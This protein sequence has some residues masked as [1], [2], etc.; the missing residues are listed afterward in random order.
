[1]KTYHITP[2]LQKSKKTRHFHVLVTILFLFMLF[3]LS[4]C[5]ST[6][7]A[8]QALFVCGRNETDQQTGIYAV[9]FS[10]DEAE[11]I[12]IT[13][14]EFVSIR[15]S[16]APDGENLAYTSVRKDMTGDGI[17][18]PVEDIGE[19]LYTSDLQGEN[20]I[21]VVYLPGDSFELFNW[22]RD[23]EQIAYLTNNDQSIWHVIDY[24]GFTSESVP[25]DEFIQVEG[26]RFS[27]LISPDGNLRVWPAPEDGLIVADEGLSRSEALKMPSLTDQ[28]EGYSFIAWAPDSTQLLLSVNEPTLSQDPEHLPQTLYVIDS[29]GSNLEQI[30]S[31]GE[32]GLF[33]EMPA[34][35]SPDTSRIAYLS[36]WED[37]GNDG[38]LDRVFPK[39]FVLDLN[40]GE[41]RTLPEDS[42]QIGFCLDW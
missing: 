2:R 28:I 3:L 31:R 36:E 9:S 22:S 24:Q 5:E 27:P 20:E 1:M 26:D 35:W 11:I 12:R 7:S 23:S 16:V 34:A 37:V 13:P 17:V 30:T 29:D 14:T 15:P 40:T 21:E 8:G 19:G 33:L 6:S 25:F 38:I 10:A 41:L 18:N 32:A 42:L 39:L 4:S